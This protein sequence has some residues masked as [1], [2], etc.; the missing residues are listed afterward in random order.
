MRLFIPSIVL[1]LMQGSLML[2]VGALPLP[3]EDGP[4][5]A[6][7]DVSSPMLLQFPS[8]SST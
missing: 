6:T 1:V 5:W 8:S 7:S 3:I 2:L 4:T